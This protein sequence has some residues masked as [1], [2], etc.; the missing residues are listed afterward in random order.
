M[1]I[2]LIEIVGIIAACCTTASFVPQ[3]MHT[4]KTK[5]VKDISL[6]MYGLFSFGLC[7]WLVY[8][9]RIKSLAIIL[10]NSITLTLACSIL[11]MKIVFNKKQDN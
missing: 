2:D 9:I 3:V 11:L 6:K 10:A 4:W 8:G 7:L 1:Q 5:S